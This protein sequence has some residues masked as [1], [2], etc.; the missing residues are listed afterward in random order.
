MIPAV[1][2]H[3]KFSSFVRQ[4]NGW[5]FT[6]IT[7]KGPDQHSYYHPLFLRGVPHLL[8]RMKRSNA[9]K[10]PCPD[11]ETEPFF[12]RIALERPLPEVVITR[13]TTKNNFQSGSSVAVLPQKEAEQRGPTSTV[14]SS[15]GP[16]ASLN[17][18]PPP[19]S[20]LSP[21]PYHQEHTL[22]SSDGSNN[23]P[24]ALQLQMTQKKDQPGYHQL[25]GSF[26]TNC[27]GNAPKP[28]PEEPTQ[29]S[30]VLPPATTMNS[31]HQTNGSFCCHCGGRTT[32]TPVQFYET[33]P[34]H[35]SHVAAFESL[36]EFDPLFFMLGPPT[37]S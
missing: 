7:R 2:G 4:A 34:A 22:N 35:H 17:L 31:S 16:S 18:V 21:P 11:Q 23:F 36:E 13:T 37:P 28:V 24:I 19:N 30:P 12:D 8:K 32:V 14:A 6:R 29:L 10:R 15:A 26:T 20:K 33:F 25:N 1:F 3:S 27:S 9:N 5:G